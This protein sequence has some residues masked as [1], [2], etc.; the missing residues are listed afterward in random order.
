MRIGI[1]CGKLMVIE[2]NWCTEV[3]KCKD[4]RYYAVL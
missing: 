2:L 1:K 3:K 4:G